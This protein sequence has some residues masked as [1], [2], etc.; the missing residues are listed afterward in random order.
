MPGISFDPRG[1]VRPFVAKA[2]IVMSKF[3]DLLC[4]DAF[5]R[6]RG[7]GLHPKLREAI[8]VDLRWH[9]KAA[10]PVVPV[11]DPLPDNVILLAEQ[12]D[13]KALGPS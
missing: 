4:M 10:S 5:A 1:H 6:T 12:R 13:I 3:T 11:P 7:C 9:S 8:E 2:G